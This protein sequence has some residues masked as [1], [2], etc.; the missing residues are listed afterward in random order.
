[1]PDRSLSLAI[2]AGA[3][4]AVAASAMVAVPCAAQNLTLTAADSAAIRIASLRALSDSV[5]RGG[6]DRV[7]WIRARKTPR[8]PAD[9]VTPTVPSAGEFRAIR[10]SFPGARLVPEDTELF[11]CPPGR[12][13][14]MPS[15]GC[16]VRDNGVIVTFEAIEA[17]DSTVQTG[18]RV[19]ASSG[20]G[21]MTWAEGFSQVFGRDGTGWKL[22]IMALSFV[23]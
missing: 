17:T 16:P 20:G 12:E 14:I 18:I 7:I 8:R 13:V 19:M 1:M 2:T 10:D 4:F 5:F 15:S 23:T 21:R 11:E 3:A 6:T 9:T 22:L